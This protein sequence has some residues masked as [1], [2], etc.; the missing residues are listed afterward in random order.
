MVKST[1]VEANTVLIAA[2]SLLKMV[3]L[4]VPV[5][6]YRLEYIFGNISPN[7]CITGGVA[8]GDVPS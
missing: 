2:Y 3:R 8:P 7:V 5:A 6:F 1:V 4:V